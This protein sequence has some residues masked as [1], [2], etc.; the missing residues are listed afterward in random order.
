MRYFKGVACRSSQQTSSQL[1]ASLVSYHESD[2][3]LHTDSTDSNVSE[4]DQYTAHTDINAS[5]CKSADLSAGCESINKSLMSTS[6][7]DHR[8]QATSQSFKN[9]GSSLLSQTFRNQPTD[10]Q[11]DQ[12]TK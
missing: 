8:H 3:P 6:V 9:C 5:V 4:Y 7:A 2:L 11:I 1:D 12:A 10:Q